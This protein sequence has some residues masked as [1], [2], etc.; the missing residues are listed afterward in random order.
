MTVSLSPNSLPEGER[1]EVSLREL[2][3]NE[4]VAK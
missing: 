4:G 1:D 3:V 2:H